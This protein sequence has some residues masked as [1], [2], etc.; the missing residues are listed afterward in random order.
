MSQQNDYLRSKSQVEYQYN[1]VSSPLNGL[2]KRKPFEIVGATPNTVNSNDI[3]VSATQRSDT[4]KYQ[5]VVSNNQVNVIDMDTG[6][7]KTVTGADNFAYLSGITKGSDV[8][9]TTVEDFTFI[10]NKTINIKDRSINKTTYHAEFDIDP[11]VYE[12]PNLELIGVDGSILT[13]PSPEE[14]GVYVPVPGIG[15]LTGVVDGTA[16]EVFTEGSV[17]Q[18]QKQWMEDL[19]NKACIYHPDDNPYS[20]SGND[21]IYDKYL[22]VFKEK[23]ARDKFIR[24]L[25]GARAQGFKLSIYLASVLPEASLPYTVSYAPRNYGRAYYIGG[26]EGI[27]PDVYTI[28]VDEYTQLLSVDGSTNLG[29]IEY[30]EGVINKNKTFNDAFIFGWDIYTDYG[31]FAEGAFD[32]GQPP[33]LVDQNEIIGEDPDT[34]L[35]IHQ[36]NICL[37]YPLSVTGFDEY[38]IATLGEFL[39]KSEISQ[40][41]YV[42]SINFVY[43]RPIIA[44]ADQVAA[45]SP[46]LP[47]GVVESVSNQYTHTCTHVSMHW[48]KIYSGDILS[49]VPT[50]KRT[51]RSDTEAGGYAYDIDTGSLVLTPFNRSTLS[52]TQVG[53]NAAYANSFGYFEE[54]TYADE[55]GVGINGVYSQVENPSSSATGYATQVASSLSGKFL[56]GSISADSG[57]IS[58][59]SPYEFKVTS[60][61]PGLITTPVYTTTETTLVEKSEETRLFVIIKQ[62]VADQTYRISVDGKLAEYTTGD[63]NAVS[64]WKPRNIL[65]QLANDLVAQG[66]SCTIFSDLFMSVSKPDFSDFT[67]DY[68]DTWNG[69]AMH[70]IKNAVSDEGELPAKFVEGIVVRVGPA[71]TGYY[72]RYVTTS[73][74][75]QTEG[76]GISNQVLNA[77]ESNYPILLQNQTSVTYTNWTAL[78]SEE[79]GRWEQCSNPYENRFIDERTMPHVLV[80][81]ADGTFTFRPIV[82]GFRAIGDSRSAAMPSFVGKQIQDVFFHR[83]RLGVLTDESLVLSRNGSFFNFF[84]STA[85]QVLDTDPIDVQV[86]H[87][88]VSLL[89]K[90]VVYNNELLLFSDNAQFLVTGGEVLSPT[91]INVKV[92]NEY[93]NASDICLPINMGSKVVFAEPRSGHMHFNEYFN[94]SQSSSVARSISAHVP[95]LVKG[96]YD[97]GVAIAGSSILKTMAVSSYIPGNYERSSRI[98]VYKFE[99]GSDGGK[100]QES[101]SIQS[102]DGLGVTRIVGIQFFGSYLYATAFTDNG[103][104]VTFRISMD[105]ALTAVQSDPFLDYVFVADSEQF[106]GNLLGELLDST[107][108]WF[109]FTYSDTGALVLTELNNS[110]L[111][112]MAIT[113]IGNNTEEDAKPWLYALGNTS[114]GLAYDSKVTTSKF[115]VV[116]KSGAPLNVD[117]L[118]SIKRVGFNVKDCKEFSAAILRKSPGSYSESRDF[119]REPYRV[120]YTLPASFSMQA[121]SDSRLLN[122]ELTSS[123]PRGFTVVSVKWEGSFFPKSRQI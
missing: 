37:V 27:D 67:F 113:Q 104:I 115:M 14:W 46:V 3:S 10:T 15:N 78:E 106:A 4:D 73:E 85:K 76:S 58:V 111:Y 69:Q 48:C 68:S 18:Q 12:Y 93:D 103:K 110:D 30:L 55:L 122:T 33:Y 90:A 11:A 100:V 13:F 86:S 80:Y 59:S 62:G 19:V 39:V 77:D 8:A 102:P 42:A 43:N 117:S 82:W 2:T 74:G 51:V 49:P 50:F 75:V 21:Y 66:L 26:V 105:D 120:D 5:I 70:C 91:T 99:E 41:R 1:M 44:T 94:V 84:P 97:F 81:N 25:L 101:W 89:K 40:G 123:D 65:Q 28:D 61:K 16:T 35:P 38:G 31:V 95:T 53:G 98:Y 7:E 96:N 116:D 83:N 71:S 107:R 34:L 24:D 112:D 20:D 87:T 119:D 52:F 9:I 57:T 108:K 47:G 6:F 72:A 23:Q 109:S 56:S 121:L 17:Q 45:M 54:T 22:P 29:P 118:L 63:T 114:V 60:M 32:L 64:T 88:K 79:A 36:P 92:A